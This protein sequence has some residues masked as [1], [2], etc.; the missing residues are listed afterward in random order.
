[1]IARWL[2]RWWAWW[3]CGPPPVT[4]SDRWLRDNIYTTG[5]DPL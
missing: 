5:K 4:M 1:M 3:W 2:G